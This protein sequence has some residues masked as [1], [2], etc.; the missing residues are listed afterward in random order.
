MKINGDKL[1][2]NPL[3]LGFPPE[4]I[5]S[6]LLQS[7]Y[8]LT[9]H[10]KGSLVVEEHH[11]CNQMSFVL[12]GGLSIRQFNL[13]GD[14]L[15]IKAFQEGDCFPAPLLFLK[16]P[17]YPFTLVAETP[18]DILSIPFPEFQELL[19]SSPRFNRNFMT[20][21]SRHIMELRFTIKVLS[22][23]SVR[24]RLLLYFEKEAR[25]LGTTTFHLRHSKTE[26]ADR[27]H[28]AR[29]SVSRELARMQ[30]EG[31]LKVQGRKVTLLPPALA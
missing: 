27:I 31:L 25:E 14:A 20:F 8:Q 22:Q 2:R 1:K 19:L 29:P 10:T 30:E 7:P 17:T 5:E 6:L 3:F 21:L 18:V 9:A 23:K 11:P 4:E 16:D 15:T 24:Q 28:V 13:D 12:S 26:L